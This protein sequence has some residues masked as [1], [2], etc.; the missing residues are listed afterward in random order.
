MR[1]DFDTKAFAHPE[2]ELP[3]V[4]TIRQRVDAPK[5]DNIEWE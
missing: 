1:I 3:D 5:L 4:W 2:I